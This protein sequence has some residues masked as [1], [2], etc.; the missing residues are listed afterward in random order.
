MITSMWMPRIL[1]LFQPDFFNWKLE[2]SA[3]V[4]LD[5]IHF[6]FLDSPS[7]KYPSKIGP[8]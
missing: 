4:G 5:P 6:A 8:P 2:L 7:L 1:K 3:E